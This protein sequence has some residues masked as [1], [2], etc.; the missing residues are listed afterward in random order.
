MA[1]KHYDVAKKEYDMEIMCNTPFTSPDAKLVNEML[2]AFENITTKF[3]CK[4][5]FKH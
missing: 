5:F 3:S 2:L 1:L 4:F